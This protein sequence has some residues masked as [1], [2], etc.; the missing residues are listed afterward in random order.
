MD[1]GGRFWLV[2][3]VGSLA[4]DLVVLQLR[5]AGRRRLIER[6]YAGPYKGRPVTPSAG[7]PAGLRTRAGL[8]FLRLRQLTLEDRSPAGAPPKG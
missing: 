6:W 2:P 4:C 3:W 1:P 7:A 8:H 5:R